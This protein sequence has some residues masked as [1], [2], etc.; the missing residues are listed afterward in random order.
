[1]AQR[2]KCKMPITLQGVTATTTIDPKFRFVNADYHHL[3][4]QRVRELL[5]D[6]TRG[7]YWVC[8]AS[9]PQCAA[10]WAK[11]SVFWR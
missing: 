7:G 8:S 2:A 6:A 11:M 10:M 9:A 3:W 4:Q 1:M 5:V